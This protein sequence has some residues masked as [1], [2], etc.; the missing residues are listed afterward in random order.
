M[1]L[2]V[3]LDAVYEGRPLRAAC[4]ELLSLG[5]DTVEFWHYQDKPLEE[6]ME[7]QQETGLKVAAICTDFVSLTLASKREDYRK[8]LAG[9]IEAAKKLGCRTIISQT[10]SE[11]PFD[12]SVQHRSIV[13]GLRSYIPM[14][15][16]SGVTLALEPLNVRVDHAG[17]YL[18]SSDE[19]VEILDEVG[20]ESVKML[21]D[22]YHQ[23]IT[24]GDIIRRICQYIPYIVHFHTAGNPGR[25]ELYDS[26]LNYKAI[27][28]AIEAT[29]YKGC[30]GLEYFPLD[31]TQKGLK[32]A[33]SIRP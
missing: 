6:L 19:C 16:D 18:Q 24:E 30:V 10:G 8:A 23:Q 1:K 32:Y 4:E 21:F 12:R 25:H 26:E 22:I 13:D 14:L 15:E 28:A 31:D 29:G 3:C 2:S 20:S 17:Y 27:F 33:M 5:L 9:T 11:E 7:L